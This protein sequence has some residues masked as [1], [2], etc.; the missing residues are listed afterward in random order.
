MLSLEWISKS[1]Y[2]PLTSHD[3]FIHLVY[4]SR[5]PSVDYEL[6][7]D[8]LLAGAGCGETASFFVFEAAPYDLFVM[9]TARCMVGSTNSLSHAL[10]MYRR[11][12]KRKSQRQL[13]V[14]FTLEDA[15][16]KG[17]GTSILM[18][19]ER[20][21][22]ALFSN[23]E[24]PLDLREEIAALQEDAKPASRGK[25][26]RRS[27]AILLGVLFVV[28]LVAILFNKYPFP[29]TSPDAFHSWTAYDTGASIGPKY[30]LS[31]TGQNASDWTSYIHNPE[32]WALRIDDQA[33]IPLHLL[34]DEEKHYQDWFQKRYPETNEIR[35]NQDYLN[36]TWLSSSLVDQVPVDDMFHF[37]HCVLAV[38]RYIKAKETGRH[39][40]GRDIDHEHM[41]HCLD[42][43]DWW[44]FPE[45][46][47]GDTVPNPKMTFSWRTKVCF[48]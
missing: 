12:I 43:L 24:L 25:L 7:L 39:V 13:C 10:D 23:L 36:A 8:S 30:Q 45:G 5:E 42:A 6:N 20:Y 28:A 17:R 27:T 46:Q 14:S 21:D 40:C 16:G 32:E 33:I 19:L 3:N 41:H 47:R 9:W 37:A 29:R 48:E 35:L 34:D 18:V 2:A 22:S 1:S 31:I 4:D 15:V 44:A 26:S 38:R 11:F